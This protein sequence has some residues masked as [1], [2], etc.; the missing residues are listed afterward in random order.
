MLANNIVNKNST[1]SITLIKK[2]S[3]LSIVISTR[4]RPNDLKDL[5]HSILAQTYLPDDVVIVDGS[6]SGNAEIIFNLFSEKYRFYNCKLRY[7]KASGRGLTESRI[8]GINSCTGEAI[9]FADDDI[10]LDKNVFYSLETFLSSNPSALG[11]QPNIVSSDSRTHDSF[12]K[13]F[14][15]AFYKVLM[16]S[17]CKKDTLSVRK[18]GESIFPEELTKVISVQRLFGCGCCYKRTVFSQLSFDTNLK[19]WGYF[20]DLDFSYRLYKKYPQSL[21][22]IASSTII[23]KTSKK[24]RA[25]AKPSALMKVIYCFY[26]FFKDIFE[27]SIT[28]LFAFMWALMGN[29]VISTSFLTYNRKSRQDWWSLIYLLEAY[30]IAL[31]NLQSIIQGRLEFFNN[32]LQE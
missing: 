2:L 14:S 24:A 25:P 19:R 21:W 7:I 8:L 12:T 11:I 4:D 6:F 20:E 30:C 17:Y 22:A 27:C 31:R 18:S 16:L 3:S 5:L 1:S 32:S 23:H 9:F 15:N 26:I 13:R 10:L 28:N 29:L